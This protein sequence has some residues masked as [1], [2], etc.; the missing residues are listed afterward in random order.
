MNL[1]RI[2]SKADLQRRA[3]EVLDPDVAGA[4]MDL[5]LGGASDASG[6]AGIIERL[7]NSVSQRLPTWKRGGTYGWNSCSELCY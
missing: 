6:R 3:G 2:R 7:R 4:E 1:L 5:R